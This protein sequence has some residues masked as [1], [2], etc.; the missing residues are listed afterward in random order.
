MKTCFLATRANA[1]C[2]TAM[3][4]NWFSCLCDRS[5]ASGGAEHVGRM[6]E[7]INAP[8]RKTFLRLRF[9]EDE[10]ADSDGEFYEDDDE[11]VCEAFPSSVSSL[12]TYSVV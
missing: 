10:D 9:A 8:T 5:D 12:A 6:G 1:L 11:M 3:D 4:N 2:N 7:Y